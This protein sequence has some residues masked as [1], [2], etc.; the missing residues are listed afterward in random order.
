MTPLASQN[1]SRVD[2]ALQG[3]E[4]HVIKNLPRVPWNKSE[5]VNKLMLVGNDLYSTGIIQCNNKSH[6]IYGDHWA[7]NQIQD[8]EAATE[9]EAL[10]TILR[11][12]PP[13]EGFV[14]ECMVLYEH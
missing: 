8:V 13:E 14:V 5:N 11:R 2:R 6:L 4:W 7:D 9:T 1:T 12:Y 3:R 10:S